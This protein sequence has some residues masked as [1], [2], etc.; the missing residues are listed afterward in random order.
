MSPARLSRAHDGRID[1]Q[2]V[3]RT[4]HDL[5]GCTPNVRDSSKGEP[6]KAMHPKKWSVGPVY[7]ASDDTPLR[8]PSILRSGPNRTLAPLLTQDD[9][10][11]E[12]GRPARRSDC[13]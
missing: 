1:L 10:L 8:R 5:G 4:T 9:N 11:P 3:T 2:T 6:L 12:A 13:R 7:D